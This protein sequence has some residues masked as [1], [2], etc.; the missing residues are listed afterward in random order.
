MDM[1]Q[2]R[3]PYMALSPLVCCLCSL[4]GE[5]D[6]HNFIHCP[7]TSRVWSYFL[8]GSPFMFCH[9]RNHQ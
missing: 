6:N 1:L 3:H 4:N 7:F 8:G 5:E 2:W 9:A